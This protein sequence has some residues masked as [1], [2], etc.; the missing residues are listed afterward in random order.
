MR[1][2][3]PLDDLDDEQLEITLRYI[4][5]LRAAGGVW[6]VKVNSEQARV[7]LDLEAAGLARVTETFIYGNHC[8]ELE[9]L[10]K[11]G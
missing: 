1:E 11:N 4:K 7:A 3:Q 9:M 10:N 2:H 8:F 6:H 5:V